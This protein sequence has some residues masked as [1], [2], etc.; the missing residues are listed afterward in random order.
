MVL[1]YVRLQGIDKYTGLTVIR[2][3]PIGFVSFILILVFLSRKDMT[4]NEQKIPIKAKLRRLDLGG[5]AILISGLCCLLLALQW[6]G[7]TL[8]WRSARIVGLCTASGIII[9]LFF[10]LQWRLGDDST[11]PLH[12]LFQRSIAVGSCFEL[13]INMCNYAV[14]PLHS[15]LPLS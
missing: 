8:P 3:L 5:A 2:N 9:I 11:M 13:L 12:V 15:P 1:L 4:A 10:L 6:G 7:T 14:S